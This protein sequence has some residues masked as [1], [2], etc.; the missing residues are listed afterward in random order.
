MYPV[1]KWD[2]YFLNIAQAIKLR[3]S[4]IR[5]QVGAVVTKD[6]RLLATGYNGTPKGITNCNEGGCPRCNSDA[7]SGTALEDCICVHAE[8]NAIVQAA[9]YG[10]RIEGADMYCT[11][12]P[13][14]DCAKLIINAGIVRVVVGSDHYNKKVMNDAM[15][16]LADADVTI[17]IGDTPKPIVFGPGNTGKR[18][19]GFKL[20]PQDFVITAVKRKPLIGRK[21]KT[22][23]DK[24]MRHG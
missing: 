22:Y 13:C 5:R 15:N 17:Q 8:Q 6:N 12:F 20:D 14:K 2:A 19:T 7:P 11:L 3:S 4:C 10:I 16:L 23:L 18:Y 9:R 1:I 21:R 24:L